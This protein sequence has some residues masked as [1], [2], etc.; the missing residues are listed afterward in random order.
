[1][2][3]V[4]ERLNVMSFHVKTQMAR[5]LALNQTTH[6]IALNKTSRAAWTGTTGSH[7]PYD[8]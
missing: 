8:R 4:E 5:R 2:S 7:S 3:T 6:H 1:V